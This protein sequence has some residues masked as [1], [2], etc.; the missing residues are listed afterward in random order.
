MKMSKK[1]LRSTKHLAEDEP[2]KGQGL[3]RICNNN[4]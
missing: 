1:R 4:L 2:K 3:Q